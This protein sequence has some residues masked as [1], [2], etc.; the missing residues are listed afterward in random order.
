VTDLQASRFEALLNSAPDAILLTDSSGRITLINRRV[1]EL[2]GYDRAELV[3]EQVELLVPERF[4]RFHAS[5]RSEYAVDP[6]TREMGAGLELYGRR[7]DGSEFPVEAS[8]ST[9]REGEETLVITIVRDASARRVVETRFRAVLE[10]APDAIVLVET[11]GRIAL[12][13]RRTEE[14]FGYEPGELRGREIEL[15]IPDGFRST[16]V[17][18]RTPTSDD[19]RVRETG[20]E[21][22]L[23]GRRR[24]ESTFPLEISFS[25]MRVDDE[26]LIIVRDVSERRAAEVQRIELASEDAVHAEAE[27]G[28]ERLAS[29]LGEIDAIVWEADARRN[30][31]SF[32]SRRAEDVL[33]YKLDRW[34][35]E[36]GF[37]QQ[38]VHP[39]DLQ[40]AERYFSE[41]IGVGEDHEYVYRVMHAD[42][43]ALW[44]RDRVRVVADST[45]ELLLRGVSVDVTS[46][47]DLEERLLQ[48]QKMDAVGQLAGGVA[49]DFNNMLVVIRGYTDILLRR[50]EDEALTDHLREIEAAA[51]RAGALTAQLLAF[52]RQAPGVAEAVD[53]NAL[54]RG[55]EPMLRSLLDED[56]ALALEEGA[57]LD[58]VRAD[59]GHLEQ[60]VVNL[61]INAR[62]ALPLGGEIRIETA[63][64]ALIESEAV[65]L[66]LRDP[67]YV[68]LSVSDDGSGM[69]NET[70]SRIFEPFFTTKDV[71]KGSGLGLAT[72]HGIVEQYGGR[73]IVDSELGRGTTF[74]LY[75]PAV[76]VPVD[77]VEPDGLIAPAV[78]V[79]PAPDLAP[80]ILLVEDELAVRKLVRFVLEHEGYEVFEAV[81]GREAL[82]Q[83]ELYPGRIDLILTDV[84]MPDIS[85]PEL[86]SRLE[87]L[88]N[89]IK[90]LFMSGYARKELLSR[91]LDEQAMKILRKPFTNE[92]LIARVAA[93][94]ADDESGP[95]R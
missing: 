88:G 26:E 63:A 78:R 43:R 60:V 68:V 11:N 22:E 42:G 59:S 57:T 75:F 47:R 38:V 81:N 44:F 40:G 3:G 53:L 52:G 70:K 46:R 1:E 58:P 95:R 30:R 50:I 31:F 7:K 20:A 65:A 15:L 25:P 8:L 82:S 86:V 69:T 90:V 72:V 39:D 64:V 27:T 6:H 17:Q 37:W 12:V 33:G 32:V 21:L 49:H 23:F 79:A 91:G 62:D 41:A 28:R 24:D 56:I 35:H 19:P 71:G 2:F 14:L 54:V 55:I 13:N 48:S 34:L 4:R 84:V 29:I 73:V 10:S 94:I 89:P 92:E 77:T 9:L 45:G 18:P 85:G 87:A 93:L 61:V 76:S 66:G 83:L 67:R 80:A 16:D 74:S 51:Q 36:D 5:H